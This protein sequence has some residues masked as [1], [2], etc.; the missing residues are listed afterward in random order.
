MSGSVVV[1]PTSATSSRAMIGTRVGDRIAQNVTQRTMPALEAMSAY[2]LAAGVYSE[3]R[4]FLSLSGSL[5][6]RRRDCGCRRRPNESTAKGSCPAEAWENALTPPSS[7]PRRSVCYFHRKCHLLSSVLNQSP[8][9][10][11]LSPQL[12]LLRLQMRLGA[13]HLFLAGASLG[14]WPRIESFIHR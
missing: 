2:E 5:C 7:R 14:K 11:S 10:S 4:G 1:A 9:P 6:P 8:F 12:P 13:L 3:G